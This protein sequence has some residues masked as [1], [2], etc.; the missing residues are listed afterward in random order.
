MNGKKGTDARPVPLEATTVAE[1][2]S[3][4]TTVALA[5]SSVRGVD[6]AELPSI[7]DVV[8][9]DALDTLFEG[10]ARTGEVRFPYCDHVVVVEGN[11]RVEIHDR[12]V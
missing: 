3:V 4:A 11:H 2:E 5:M 1:D 10:G 12:L 7:N 9:T 8:N 6:A